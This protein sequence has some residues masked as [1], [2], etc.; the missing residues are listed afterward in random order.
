MSFGEI[1]LVLLIL[2]VLGN[3]TKI[4]ALIIKGYRKYKDLGEKKRQREFEDDY[5]FYKIHKKE[6]YKN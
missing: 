6:Y 2:Y 4:I 3:F 1:S 5:V